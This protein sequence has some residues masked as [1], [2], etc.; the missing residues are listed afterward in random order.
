MKEFYHYFQHGSSLIHN[1]KP[2]HLQVTLQ[3]MREYLQIAEDRK[4]NEN[5]NCMINILSG[6]WFWKVAAVS[7]M[8]KYGKYDR[9]F[10]ADVRKEIRPYVILKSQLSPVRK[11][12]L[13]LFK[14]SFRLYAKMYMKHKRK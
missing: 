13:L 4:L 6:V 10:I 1:Y 8:I 12:Q 5:H 2:G 14:F 3:A 7:S 9:E 11:I